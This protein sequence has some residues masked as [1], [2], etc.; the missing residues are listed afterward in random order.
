MNVLYDYTA[1]SATSPKR[2]RL[3]ERTLLKLV[4]LEQKD[5]FVAVSFKRRSGGS[6]R[7][8][9]SAVAEFCSGVFPKL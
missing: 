1:R 2:I 5:S 9:L 8:L 6:Y 7:C 4:S 3:V